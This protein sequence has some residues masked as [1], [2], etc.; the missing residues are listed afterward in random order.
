MSIKLTIE[1]GRYF[2]A[3]LLGGGY[4][5]GYFTYFDKSLMAL[6]NVHDLIGWDAEVPG[7]IDSHPLILKDLRIGTSEFRLKP[8]EAEEYGEKWLLSARTIDGAAQPESRLFLMGPDNAPDVFDIYREIPQRPATPD[9]KK[10]L[11]PVGFMFP[12]TTTNAIE[13]AIRR[14]DIDPDDFYPEDFPRN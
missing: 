10:T 8:K 9:E 14:I 13:V 11:Q 5:Y 4:A 1:P 6:C 3:P 2:I 7:D 12:P